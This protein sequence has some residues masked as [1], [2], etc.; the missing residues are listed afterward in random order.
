MVFWKL[1]KGNVFCHVC[2]S[3][4]HSVHSGA[5]HVTSTHDALEHFPSPSPSPT[6]LD[7]GP[8]CTGTISPYPGFA[9]PP[10]CS[11]LFIKKHAWLGNGWFAS[12]CNDFLF[13]VGTGK[14]LT[15]GNF[16]VAGKISLVLRVLHS[17]LSVATKM[18][19]DEVQSEVTS[20]CC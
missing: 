13:V 1:W 2:L 15:G 5:P 11:N 16:F 3:G 4:S 6:P 14:N 9:P 7:M 17:A 8:H 12:Y 10:I 18:L 20:F 19:L